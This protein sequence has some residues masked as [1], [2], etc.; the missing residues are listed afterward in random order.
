MDFWPFVHGLKRLNPIQSPSI[1]KIIR[2]A[3]TTQGIDKGHVWVKEGLREHNLTAQL[4]TLVQNREHL[5]Q[6]YYGL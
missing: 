1:D 6:F 5:N 3:H 2:L 4:Q